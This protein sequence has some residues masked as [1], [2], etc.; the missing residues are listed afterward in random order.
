MTTGISRNVDLMFDPSSVTQY[1]QL[2]SYHKRPIYVLFL[3]FSE[4]MPVL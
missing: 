2:T 3:S 4:V 1:V